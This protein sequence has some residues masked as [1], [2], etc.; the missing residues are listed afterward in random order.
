MTSVVWDAGG[1][2][3]GVTVG[4]GPEAATTELF[5]D[6]AGN[7]TRVRNG[8]GFDTILTYQPWNLPETRIEPEAT[9]GQPVGNRTWTT[10]YDGAG[11]V[12]KEQQPGSVVLNR[13]FDD[14]GRPF[15]KPPQVLPV[16][17]RSPMTWQAGCHRC[18]IRRGR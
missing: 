16:R 10:S 7:N 14:A 17:G 4:T 11:L 9:A 2:M 18:R 13:V 12:T 6:T 15:R 5:Y 3:S 1:R 8:R